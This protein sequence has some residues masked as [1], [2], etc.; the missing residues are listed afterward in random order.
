MNVKPKNYE[1]P[2]FYDRVI[3]L[4]RYT[5]SWNAIRR[6]FSA[7]GEIIPKLMNV[8]RAVSSEGFGRAKYYAQVRELLDKDRKF[9]AYFESES[10]ELPEFFSDRVRSDLGPLWDWLP[11]GALYHDPNAYLRSE[12]EKP[13]PKVEL[14]TTAVGK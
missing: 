8:L 12:Q 9:R 11:E 3:D 7:S 6:R 5:F 14:S 13:A 10:T 2:E 4:T 1:W